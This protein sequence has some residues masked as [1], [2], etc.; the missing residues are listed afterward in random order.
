MVH[1]SYKTERNSES[2]S[3]SPSQLIKKYKMQQ[4]S[5]LSKKTTSKDNDVDGTNYCC[6]NYIKCI[7]NS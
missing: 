4:K 3:S 6:E 2:C 7:V 5:V 1:C